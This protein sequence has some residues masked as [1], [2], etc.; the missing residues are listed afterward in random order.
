M[1]FNNLNQ[2]KELQF[3]GNRLHHDFLP[4]LNWSPKY[5]KLPEQNFRSFLFDAVRSSD[6]FVTPTQGHTGIGIDMC[7]RLLGLQK[8]VVQGTG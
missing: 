5:F 6:S 8:A 3:K 1:P 4:P 7:T 2:V